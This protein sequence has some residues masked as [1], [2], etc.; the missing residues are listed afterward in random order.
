M[1]ENQGKTLY[2]VLDVDPIASQDEIRKAYHREALKCHPDKILAAELDDEVRNEKKERFQEIA[3]AYEKL[4]DPNNR[5]VYDR[6]VM[7]EYLSAIERSPAPQFGQNPQH[8]MRLGSLPPEIIRQVLSYFEPKD[9]A[10]WSQTNQDNYMTLDRLAWS[11]TFKNCTIENMVH[12]ARNTNE[13]TSKSVKKCL[14]SYEETTPIEM[15]TEAQ[16]MSSKGMT[17]LQRLRYLEGLIRNSSQAE[18]SQIIDG[19]LRMQSDSYKESLFSSI[20]LLGKP[21]DINIGR[22]IDKACNFTNVDRSCAEILGKIAKSRRRIN[23]QL[24]PVSMENL[25]KIVKQAPHISNYNKQAQM[26]SQ[27]DAVKLL[28]YVYQASPSDETDKKIIRAAEQFW[29]PESSINALLNVAYHADKTSKQGIIKVMDRSSWSNAHKCEALSAMI[30]FAADSAGLTHEI[31]KA[32]RKMDDEYQRGTLL[33]QVINKCKDTKNLN[34]IKE[35]EVGK[36]TDQLWVNSLNAGITMRTR[37]LTR[38]TQ[39]TGKNHSSG[40]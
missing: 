10:R 2:D 37:T 33:N 4:K 3:T 24:Y 7:R 35:H 18:I 36:F 21:D 15:L 38:E 11:K 1:N 22:M 40:R 6:T 14:L 13:N 16:S 31:V 32:S 12:Y 5:E 26:R 29:H 30:N 8:N 39:A 23:D 9:L 20:L 19:S 34:Q 27:E 25:D 28:S 17:Q